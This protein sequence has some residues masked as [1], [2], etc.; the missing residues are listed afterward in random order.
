MRAKRP[1]TILE[2]EHR[3]IQKVVAAMLVLVERLEES[4][5]VDP[6]TLREMVEFMRVFADRC[7]HGKEEVHLFPALERKGVPVRGC[8]MGVLIAEHQ[9]G[10][11]LVGALADAV[12][13]YLQGDPPAEKP[14]LESLKGITDLYPGHIWKEDYLLFPM[15]NKVLN[16]Q[17]Q[18]ELRD[19]F[20][21]VEESVGMDVHERFLHLADKWD[22]EL[23]SA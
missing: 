3:S 14:L 4:Q 15:T 17:E 22:K 16:R 1:T 21:E 12:D 7:H 10:R 9:R 11:A 18:Q 13:G 19:R 8:P 2:I 23:K 20:E 5:K 6:A